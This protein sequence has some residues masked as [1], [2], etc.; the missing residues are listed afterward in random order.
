MEKFLIKLLTQRRSQ[1]DKIYV[2]F[3]PDN[4]YDD[5]IKKCD[6][7]DSEQVNDYGYL[8]QVK[9]D[10]YDGLEDAYKEEFTNKYEL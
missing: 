8:E 6:E 2:E 9:V 5:N 3:V 7:I 4:E 10:L 1:N